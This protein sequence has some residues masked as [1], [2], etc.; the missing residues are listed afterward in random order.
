M[1]TPSRL[2]VEWHWRKVNSRD[3][4]N[5][6]IKFNIF[7]ASPSNQ[8]AGIKHNTVLTQDCCI[9]S[10]AK[11]I[12]LLIQRQYNGEDGLPVQI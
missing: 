1:P 9:A 8:N 5:M 6:A 2:N 11:K 10:S 7:E 12:R 4:V 3:K